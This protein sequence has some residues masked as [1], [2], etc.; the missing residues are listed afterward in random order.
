MTESFNQPAGAGTD[1]D[2]KF[3]V[4]R[5]ARR[6]T[7]AARGNATKPGKM[8]MSIKIKPAAGPKT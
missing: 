4:Q 6:W 3:D 8:R 2:Y 5:S 7:V 1:R